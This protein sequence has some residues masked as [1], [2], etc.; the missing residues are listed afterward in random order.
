V[1]AIL[2]CLAKERLSTPGLQCAGAKLQSTTMWGPG[3]ASNCS[4]T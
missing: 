4:R 2:T 3:S 1:G